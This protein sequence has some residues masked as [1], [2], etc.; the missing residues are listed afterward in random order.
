[1]VQQ[2]AVFVPKELMAQDVTLIFH[3][4]RLIHVLMVVRAMKD[5]EATTLVIA[6]LVSLVQT[7]VQTSTSVHLA[8]VLTVVHALKGMGWKHHASVLKILVALT[9][10]PA[11]LV[12]CFAYRC[13][14]N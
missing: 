13:N 3:S 8:P 10:Q 14:I 4:V 5:L 12:N 11:F 6:L 2:P 9:V 1:M 7:A